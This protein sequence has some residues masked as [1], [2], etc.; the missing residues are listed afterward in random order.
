MPQ[1]RPPFRVVIGLLLL[2]LHVGLAILY[3]SDRSP[4]TDAA[5]SGLPLDDAWIHL[6]YG[7]SVASHGI[8]AYNGTIPEAGF[9]SPLWML[10]SAA[11]HWLVRVV[12]ISVVSGLKMS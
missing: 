11:V 4:G 8:P 7:R 1:V 10:N 6:V 2:S 5:L 9:T 3:V 12:P